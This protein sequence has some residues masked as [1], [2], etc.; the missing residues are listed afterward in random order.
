MITQVLVGLPAQGLVHQVDDPKNT[1]YNTC[2]V[3][4]TLP[5]GANALKHVFNKNCTLAGGLALFTRL[6]QHVS[7]TEAEVLHVIRALL[8]HQESSLC[9]NRPSLLLRGNSYI[10]AL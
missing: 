10:P 8:N 9:F 4:F 5:E 2:L 7:N 3:Y 1:N 6:F